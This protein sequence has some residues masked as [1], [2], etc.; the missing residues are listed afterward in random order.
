MNLLGE[1]LR[2]QGR[3][4]GKYVQGEDHLIE[5]D[6]WCE[7]EGQGVTTPC[8]ATILLPARQ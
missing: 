2:V 8:K 6:L 7:T 5:A 4:T 3:V 1:T